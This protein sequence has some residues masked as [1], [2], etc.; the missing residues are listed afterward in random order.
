MCLEMCGGM[1]SSVV[2]VCLLLVR[3]PCAGVGGGASYTSLRSL[4]PRTELR[5]LAS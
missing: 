5:R 2:G 3:G 1:L 4:I